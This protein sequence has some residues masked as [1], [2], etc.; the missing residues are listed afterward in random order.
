MMV[1]KFE[2]ALIIFGDYLRVGVSHSDRVY[3]VL[4]D[5]K[6]SFSILEEVSA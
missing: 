5:M 2:E 6:K 4:V 3:E 1:E